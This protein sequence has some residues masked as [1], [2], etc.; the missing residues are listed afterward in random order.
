MNRVLIFD[1]AKVLFASRLK[2]GEVRAKWL[3]R[4]SPDAQRLVRFPNFSDFVADLLDK[5]DELTK[6]RSSVRSS[7]Y[8]P[9]IG[10]HTSLHICC[11]IHSAARYSW[12]ATSAS[13]STS[14]YWPEQ[15]V[16][17]VPSPDS[18]WIHQAYTLIARSP[19]KGIPISSMNVPIQG[20]SK[21]KSSWSSNGTSEI[22]AAGEGSFYI[23]R[24]PGSLL[25]WA[26]A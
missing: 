14:H 17:P 6:I 19:L 26:R 5:K 13:L 7:H 1:A 3:R 12:R 4:K 9:Q 23:S 16:P 15:T 22:R 2:S 8:H 24:R 21:R 10:C 18:L 11:I 25:R 20:R